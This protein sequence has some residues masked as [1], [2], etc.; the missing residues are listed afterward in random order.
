MLLT[1][2]ATPAKQGPQYRLPLAYQTCNWSQ[3]ALI[4]FQFANTWIFMMPLLLHPGHSV[5]SLLRPAT[6]TSSE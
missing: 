6:N 3:L 5:A 1:E 4:S 2:K